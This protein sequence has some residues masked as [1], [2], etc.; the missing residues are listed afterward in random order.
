[1]NRI[2]DWLDEFSGYDRR[3]IRALLLIT[4]ILGSLL[5]AEQVP[6]WLDGGSSLTEEQQRK[7][8]DEAGAHPTPFDVQKIVDKALKDAQ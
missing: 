4:V 8:I 2:L 3:G 5:L 7:I 1:M 6:S